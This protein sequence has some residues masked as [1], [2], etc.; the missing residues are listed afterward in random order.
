[1]TFLTELDTIIRALYFSL[2]KN[3]HMENAQDKTINCISFEIITATIKA[4]LIEGSNNGLTA[5]EIANTIIFILLQKNYFIYKNPQMS[6]QIG[7]VYLKRQKVE[8]NNYSL[9]A[10]T[11]NSTLEDIRALTATW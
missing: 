2:L 10:I 11:N 7:Y 8:I 9:D 3:I 4:K 6:L 5:L 1:M